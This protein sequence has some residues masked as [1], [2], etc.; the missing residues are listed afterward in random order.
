MIWLGPRLLPFLPG[1]IIVLDIATGQP[2]CLAS[3][4]G[5][6]SGP[7]FRNSISFLRDIGFLCSFLPLALMG[8]QQCPE[9]DGVCCISFGSFRLFS[10][11]LGVVEGSRLDSM[12]F[13][14]WLLSSSTSAPWG[15]LSHP[16]TLHPVFLVCYFLTGTHSAVSNSL[17]I[18]AEL[19]LVESS[20]VFTDTQVFKSHLCFKAPGFP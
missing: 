1:F 10:L 15:M 5:L 2:L 9:S 3:R 16:L 17:T 20:V 19:F 7:F 18:S 8:F 14:Q 4:R 6:L 13:S 12:S 11:V